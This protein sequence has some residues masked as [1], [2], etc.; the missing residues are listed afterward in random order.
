MKKSK[1]S[2]YWKAIRQK[3]ILL[4]VLAFFVG[5]IL[6]LTDTTLILLIC[7]VAL[8]STW[9][10]WR[11]YPINTESKLILDTLKK[12]PAVLI[13]NHPQIIAFNSTPPCLAAAYLCP[14][15]KILLKR[16]LSNNV[17]QIEGMEIATSQMGV[18]VFLLLKIP[19]NPYTKI[20]KVF[21]NFQ[22]VIDILELHLQAKFKPAERYQT[23]RL[24]GLENYLQKTDP[25]STKRKNRIRSEKQI[26]SQMFEKKEPLSQKQVLSDSISF[27]HPNVYEKDFLENQ[28]KDPRSPGVVSVGEVVE[29]EKQ[30]VFAKNLSIQ[31]CLDLS[32]AIEEHLR[33]FRAGD[34]TRIREP[35]HLSRN[36][37]YYLILFKPF[38]PSIKRLIWICVHE[39]STSSLIM[40][41]GK[42]NEVIRPLFQEKKRLSN[43][44]LRDI[45]DLCEHIVKKT[46]KSKTLTKVQSNTYLMPKKAKRAPMIIESR[47]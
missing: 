28:I 17:D 26:D 9:W 23:T 38:N 41:Y 31:D 47:D 36:S 30:V 39:K 19:L 32:I 24:F 10:Q 2:K 20:K 5:I 18:E 27:P 6:Q 8:V 44:D 34:Q 42:I 35:I 11:P 13:K 22:S 14:V 33:S 15:P 4:T 37:S 16:V 43:T 29:S 45:L 40:G 1:I 7:S 21:Q 46:I 25:I 12:Y 3:N